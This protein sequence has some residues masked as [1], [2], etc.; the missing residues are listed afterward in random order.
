MTGWGG[1]SRLAK[2]VKQ[3]E[4]VRWGKVERLGW[5]GEVANLT[6]CNM[7]TRQ[8][9]LTPQVKSSRAQVELKSSPE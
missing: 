5:Q 1:L 9:D 2:Q 8:L 4:V 7:S 3:G 6:C